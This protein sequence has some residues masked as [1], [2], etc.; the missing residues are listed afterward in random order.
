AYRGTEEW[1]LCYILPKVGKKWGLRQNMICYI[2][3]SVW[4][5]RFLC[6]RKSEPLSAFCI[7]HAL[8]D[9]FDV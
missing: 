1:N 4:F 7:I 2:L 8:S 6:N 5:I 3:P 9:S